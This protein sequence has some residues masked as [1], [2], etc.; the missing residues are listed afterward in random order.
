MKIV[1]EIMIPLSHDEKIPLYQQIYEYIK[2]AIIDGKIPCGEKL[3]ST[4]FLA[5]HLQVSRSTVELAYEQL[6]SEGYIEP[7]PYRGYFICDVSDL[8]DLRETEK[9]K[10]RRKSRRYKR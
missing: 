1:N 8:F 4:R 6:V 2:A 7:Q 10:K 5:A 9:K 3:P